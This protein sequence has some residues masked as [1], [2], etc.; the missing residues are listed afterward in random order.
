MYQKHTRRSKNIVNY[1]SE[2]EY[3]RSHIVKT[4]TYTYSPKMINSLKSKK[5]DAKQPQFLRL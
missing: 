3:S 1:T 2:L 4:Q 5:C